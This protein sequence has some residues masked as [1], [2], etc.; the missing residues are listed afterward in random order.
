MKCKKF[1]A[2]LLS[3]LVVLMTVGPS[4]TMV[5]GEEEQIPVSFLDKAKMEVVT[6][7][8][9]RAEPKE[10]RTAA[11][12]AVSKQKFPEPVMDRNADNRLPGQ[13]FLK[14]QNLTSPGTLIKGGLTATLEEVDLT[15]GKAHI[16]NLNNPTSRVAIS[17]PEIASVVVISPTQIQLVGNSVGV[18]NLLIWDNNEPDKYAVI[19]INV[20]RDV[21][22]LA[23]QIRMI[24][25]RIN[26]MP[27]AA[28]DSVI[29]TGMAESREQSQLAVEISRA[30][31][32][33][34]AGTAGT[35]QQSSL[36]P[37]TATPGS[38]PNIINLIEIQGEP[39]TKAQAVREML[40]EIDPSIEMEVVP[41]SDG[42]EKVLLTGKV[43]MASHV[44]KAVNTA[45]I[46]YGQPGLQVVTGPGGNAVRPTGNAQ[47]QSSN[48]FNDNMDINILQGSIITDAS[49]NVV[50]M[51]EVAY[52]PQIRARVKILDVSRTALK[53]LGSNYLANYGDVGVG[54]FSGTQ[55][56]APG[57]PIATFDPQD[58]GSIIGQTL[59]RTS[60]N[61]AADSVS[62]TASFG[63]GVNPIF[64]DGVT[65]FLTLNQ[66][67]ALAISALVE[68]RKAR[69]L[70]EPVLTMLSGE[71]SSFLAGGEVPI[72][73][74][75]TN[76][77]ISVQFHEFGIRLNLVATVKDDGKIH[78]QIAPEVSSVDNANS[79]STNQ[80]VVPGF[81]TRRFQTT[82]ELE[83][84][85]S[86]VMAGLFNQ[87]ETDAASKFPGIGSIP[88]IGSFF[89]NKWSDRR[90]REM[91][92]IIQPEVM[93]VPN[94]PAASSR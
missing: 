30:Y 67:H 26:V 8:A 70:A 72:P 31:F 16:I 21:S 18:A 74:I 22:V 58:T 77:Q 55:S 90:D 10:L 94:T 52:R 48:S 63:A 40:K 5:Y 92:V 62:R 46:F 84:G 27:M 20:H 19:D 42:V 29:L 11:I 24:N 56:P 9:K 13:H 36:S 7:T 86:F 51:L 54:S 2:F 37:G 15:L 88:I 65:Q 60:G 38:A 81:A 64:G 43:R 85:Q 59:N 39:S 80:V 57:K 78:M 32:A 1:A 45:S 76:G 6:P 34:N 3:S 17:N 87:E 61:A 33:G 93:M 68:R 35:V 66:K 79:V 28:V 44:S 53:Q 69:T 83:E 75:G 14:A 89:R 50:S 71:K 4:R 41:G 73:V 82:V 91:V 47:F 12:P 25:P 49:G 23:K